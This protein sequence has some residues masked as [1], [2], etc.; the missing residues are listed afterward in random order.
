MSLRFVGVKLFMQLETTDPTITDCVQYIWYYSPLYL[1]V[2]LTHTHLRPVGKDVEIDSIINKNRNPAHFSLV[3]SHF[4]FVHGANFEK[5]LYHFGITSLC[6]YVLNPSRK[7]CAY[8]SPSR[9]SM[10]SLFYCIHNALSVSILSSS[11]ARKT[12]T[13]WSLH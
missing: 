11:L 1:S 8:I 4:L 13:S 7:I 3:S 2:S 5:L 10:E 9:I 12:C 6:L